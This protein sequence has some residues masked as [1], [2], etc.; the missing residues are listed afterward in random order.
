MF[1]PLIAA[2]NGHKWEAATKISDK[3]IQNRYVWIRLF[4][5]HASYPQHLSLVEICC[6]EKAYLGNPRNVHGYQV[7]QDW[8]GF[9]KGNSQIRE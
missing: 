5:P 4:H 3:G 9:E 7:C 6:L 8:C 2:L 1:M